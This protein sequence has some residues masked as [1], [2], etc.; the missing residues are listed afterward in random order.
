MRERR[1]DKLAKMLAVDV[2]RRTSLGWLAGT[3]VGALLSAPF[4]RQ[5]AAA[6]CSAAGACTP[7]HCPKGPDCFCTKTTKGKAFC[8]QNQPTCAGLT[9]CS[10]NSQC[11][12]AH[13]RGWKCVQS[14]CDTLVCLPKCGSSSTLSSAQSLGGGPTPARR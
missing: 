1:F 7:A 5:A 11:K 2:S 3:S 12:S 4:V 13:G 6:K 14:C 10:S 8:W 9:Q